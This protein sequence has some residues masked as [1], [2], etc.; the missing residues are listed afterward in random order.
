M[1]ILFLAHRTPYPPNK[2]EKIRSYHILSTLAERHEVSLV[3]WVDDPRDLEHQSLLAKICRGSV[4]PIALNPLKAKLRGLTSM[5]CG[6][7]FSEGYFF[8]PGFQ[9]VVNRVLEQKR[10]D[11]FYVF[12]S[13]MARYVENLSHIPTAV[14]FV[15]VDSEKWGQLASFKRFPASGLF[16]LEKERLA[17]YEIGVSRWCRWSLFVSEAEANLFRTMGG[18]GNIVALPNGVDSDLLRFPMVRPRQSGGQSENPAKLVFAGTMNYFPNIDA[19]FY[20]AHEIFPLIQSDY[21]NVTFDIVGRCPARAVR[22]LAYLNGVQVLGEV[23]DI[24]PYLLQADVSVAPIRI[25]RG[26]QNK[27]LEAIAV[28]IPVVTTSMAAAGIKKLELGEELLVGDTPQAFAKQIIRLLRDRKL[29]NEIARKARDRV[30]QFYNW[31]I[32]GRQLDDLIAEDL[33]EPQR[34]A[35]RN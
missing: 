15:D 1:K 23:D 31:K 24:R 32:I 11:L 30:V 17:R 3:Y 21:P 35:S 18:H 9:H 4:V 28:G 6:R 25:A 8:S 20:F 34:A 7:S 26:V 33:S 22:K 5:S 13:P 10:F 19:A 2:G 27:I 12:S 14:D 16:R 29:R